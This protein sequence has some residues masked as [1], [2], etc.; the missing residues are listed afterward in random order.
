[1]KTKILI[2][3]LAV[4]VSNLSMFAQKGYSDKINQFNSQGK[5]EGLWKKDIGK[6]WCNEVYYHNGIECGVFKQYKKSGELSIFGKYCE[7][8]MCG[9][10][11]HFGDYGHLIMTFKNFAPNI[12]SIINEVDG[13]KHTPDYKCYSQSYYPN[14]NI[15][16]EGL[17]LWSD[18]DSPESDTSHE[19]GEWKY[20]DESGKLVRTK[21]FK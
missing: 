3:V 12:Y 16:D 5:K 6:N 11:Y 7:G 2:T 13:K 19:Y 21:E 10:W 4:C 15:K 8:K 1:M 17:L 20:Y 14:G 9:T 18:G